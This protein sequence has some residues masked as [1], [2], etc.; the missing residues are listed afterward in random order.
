MT[1]MK[2]KD[3]FPAAFQAEGNPSFEIMDVDF[4]SYGDEYNTSAKQDSAIEHAVLSHDE[5]VEQNKRLG[6]KADR[7]A[8]MLESVVKL[9]KDNQG[10]AMDTHIEFITKRHEIEQLLSEIKGEDGA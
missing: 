10:D 8:C 1:N 2:M 4:C 6:W 3:L 7:L 9:Q 5:L